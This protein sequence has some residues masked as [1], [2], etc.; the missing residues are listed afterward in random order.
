[1]LLCLITEHLSDDD[2]G[3]EDGDV[4]K[5]W[6]TWD[7]ECK[8]E[9]ATAHSYA[10]DVASQRAVVAY[11]AYRSDDGYTQFPGS[12]FT[13]QTLGAILSTKAKK[14]AQEFKPFLPKLEGILA[15][16]RIPAPADDTKL[17]YSLAAERLLLLERLGASTP[18]RWINPPSRDT[19][20]W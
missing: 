16:S 19:A 5:P 4:V 15:G 14:V 6:K 20:T 9:R 17:H 10:A 11:F 8:P 1:M 18:D 3:G 12:P 13:K 7:I 2:T